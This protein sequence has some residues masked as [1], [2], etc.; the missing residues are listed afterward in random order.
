MQTAV[1]KKPCYYGQREEDYAVM[2]RIMFIITL[3]FISSSHAYAGL[4][5]DYPRG[6]KGEVIAEMWSKSRNQ[7][8]PVVLFFGHNDDWGFCEEYLE[9]LK[10]R[11]SY[12]YRCVENK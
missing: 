9:M 1:L 6:K 12:R 11:T 10:K 2:I 4:F 3:L 8:D 5:D 7:W